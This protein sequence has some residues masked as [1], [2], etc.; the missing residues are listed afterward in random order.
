MKRWRLSILIVVMLTGLLFLRWEVWRLTTHGDDEGR[1]AG[2][3][4]LADVGAF[5]AD[6][7]A[8]ARAVADAVAQSGERPEEFFAEVEVTPGN[9]VVVFHLWHRSAWDPVNRG[10]VGNPGGKCRDV[11]FDPRSGEVIQTLFWQ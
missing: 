4:P 10:V 2:L 1:P 8:G 3:V 6:R 7:Q 5:P 9:G 11:H